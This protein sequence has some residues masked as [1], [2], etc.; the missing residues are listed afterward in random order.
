[1]EHVE[2]EKQLKNLLK[3]GWIT[4]FPASFSVLYVI[5]YLQ[6]S[7][8]GKSAEMKLL[9]SW[10]FV[11]P[12]IPYVTWWFLLSW[13]KNDVSSCV[14]IEAI[15]SHTVGYLQRHGHWLNLRAQIDLCLV[16]R[17]DCCIDRDMRKRK[18]LIWKTYALYFQTNTKYFGITVEPITQWK[19]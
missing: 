5:Q 18:S 7:S 19:R 6:L 4:L 16:D 9:D 13:N 17:H 8:E 2:V 1:M 12:V 11:F 3:M 10:Y 15:S 14:I